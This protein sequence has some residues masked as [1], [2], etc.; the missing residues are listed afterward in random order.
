MLK[1][2]KMKKLTLEGKNVIFKT[3][4]ISKIVFRSFI[5]TVPE[6][7]IYE[8]EKRQKAFLWKNSTRKIKY[9]TLCNDY[10]TGELKNVDFAN[11]IALQCSWI[12]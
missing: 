8:L 4:E 6:H 7:I 9:E 10:K 11:T 1:I 2:W 3:I 5:T 12:R